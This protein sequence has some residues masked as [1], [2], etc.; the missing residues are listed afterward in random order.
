MKNLLI[1]TISTLFITQTSCS[2]TERLEAAET[3]IAAA[4]AN[5][6]EANSDYSSCHND[7]TCPPC[8]HCCNE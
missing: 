5:I 8:S 6:E 3:E 4:K 2:L 7:C 1:F